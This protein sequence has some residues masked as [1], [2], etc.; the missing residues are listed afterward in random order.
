MIDPNQIA[1]DPERIRANLA[2]RGVDPAR[3]H[4]VARIAAPSSR[5]RELITERW[6]PR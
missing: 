4:D 5:R 2:R 1:E 6:P 3:D